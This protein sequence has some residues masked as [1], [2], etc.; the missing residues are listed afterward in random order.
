MQEEIWKDVKGYEGLYQVSSYG[1]IYSVPR[2]SLNVNGKRVVNNGGYLK[3]SVNSRG[4]YNVSLCIDRKVKTHSVH[5][6]VACAF[7]DSEYLSKRLVVD[8]I[9]DD[10]SNNNLS[11]LSVVTPRFNTRKTQGNYSSK[12][13]GVSF[14]KNK[15]RYISEIQVDGRTIYLGSFVSEYEA[16]NAYINF[17][18]TL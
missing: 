11:N 6:I 8:H 15:K 12:Y 14:N 16:G 1:R 2:T 13:K 4:Y 5:S 7:L 18:K 3:P 17:L 10:K 9:D